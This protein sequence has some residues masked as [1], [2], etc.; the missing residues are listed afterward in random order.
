MWA[1]LQVSVFRQPRPRNKEQLIAKVKEEWASIAQEITMNLVKSFRK[2]IF[3]QPVD[4]TYLLT[5]VTPTFIFRGLKI[6]RKTQFLHYTPYSYHLIHSQITMY[7]VLGVI[8]CWSTKSFRV[9][10]V[11]IVFFCR[12]S[13]QVSV[14]FQS[15]TDLFYCHA[16]VIKT[17]NFIPYMLSLCKP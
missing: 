13:D 9:C 6:F 17:L 12:F 2:R 15:W 3:P 5:V 14:N 4:L 7:L 11:A 16:S 10:N 1:K 8:F